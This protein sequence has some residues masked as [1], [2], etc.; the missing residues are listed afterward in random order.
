MPTRIQ[1]Q[2][3][4]H[5]EL[6]GR[7]SRWKWLGRVCLFAGLLL[8]PGPLLSRLIPRRDAREGVL[9]AEL[10]AI[11]SHQTQDDYEI[12]EVFLGVGERG[13]PLHIPGFRLFT[14]Q[15][16]GPDIFEPI[17]WQ[18]RILLFLQRKK[19]DSKSWEPTARGYCFFWVQ[20]S[21]GVF[22]L[23]N[24]ARQ[25]VD[26]RQQFEQAVRVPDPQHRVEVLYP[27]L[28]DNGSSF[29]QHTREELLKEGTVA[30]DYIADRLESM[31]L[32][33]RSM[34]IRLEGKYGGDKLHA[35]LV[36]HLQTEQ[37]LWDDYVNAHGEDPRTS[38][39]LWYGS[40]EAIRYADADMAYTLAG[41]LNFRD[42]ADL[43]V[44]RPLA[45]WA[46]QRD[47]EGIC[48]YALAAFRDM[49]E[50][51]SLPVIEAL[52]KESQ[53]H[54]EYFGNTF[55][56]DVGGALITHRFREAIPQLV[57]FLDDDFIWSD[58]VN[59]SLSSIVGYNLGRDPKA[60]LEWYSRHQP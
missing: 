56:Y 17:S 6:H 58:Q 2:T 47:L 5:R 24:I 57:Q 54:P 42:R 16:Y 32:D 10:V 31:T 59:K 13:D 7:T 45:L 21:G 29:F 38:N 41:L 11:V 22:Q 15:Q 14:V 40:P 25:A 37:A 46:R 30:G 39:A 26:L 50:R 49:P 12:E 4:G 33:Q 9:D 8:M 23:R 27:F 1:R 52:W 44:I 43:L 51:A 3:S 19:D 48:S 20:D 18:T 55:R 53:V 60:W 35:A 36:H 34:L 28:W